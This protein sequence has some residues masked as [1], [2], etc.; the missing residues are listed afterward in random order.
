MPLSSLARRYG[1][2]AVVREAAP[3]LP[4]RAPMFRPRPARRGAVLP[5]VCIMLTV[6]L[7]AAA[8]AVDMGRVYLTATEVQAAAD[9]GALA[10]A[11]ASQLYPN[12]AAY[13]GPARAQ[14]L[15]SGNR[16]AG[17][18]GSIASTDVTPVFY[19]PVAN[20]TTATTYSGTVNAVQTTARARPLYVFGGAIGLSP[21]TVSRSTT[22]WVANMVGAACVRPLAP[23]YTRIYED[24]NHLTNRPYS[25]NNQYAPDVTQALIAQLSPA[26]GLPAVY[27]TFVLIPPWQREAPW[28]SA[29][30]PNSGSWH[31]IDFSRANDYSA[32]TNNISA[33]IGSTA[34]AASTS[35]VGSYLHPFS[36]QLSD[37]TTIL[38]YV[39]PGFV[40]LCNR[41][42]NAPDATCRNADGTVGVQTR[43][44][45][46]DSIPNP[47]GPFSQKVRM[48]TQL[49]VM[50][51]F[52]TPNDVCAPAQTTDGAGNP[53][54]WQMPPAFAGGPPVSTGYPAGTMVVLLDGPVFGNLTP[55]VVLGNTLSLTQ[56]LIL[57][58]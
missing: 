2:P 21:P 27:R 9:A 49:R 48:V 11:S 46:S 56:R 31:T 19:D 33:P 42:G 51:Y 17:Q 29:G 4:P 14:Q 40:Q 7:A 5:F 12:Y 22:A 54:S 3:T 23:P 38:N 25:S 30:Q 53:Q 45:L 50:C 37:T 1:A 57:V 52:Q 35:T 16:A 26:Y 28:D 44:A 20:T 32:L 8:L 34:C 18:A 47:S 58:R 15:A 55:D 10:A 43:M 24:A 13:Y 36:W 6:L 39:K 41:V